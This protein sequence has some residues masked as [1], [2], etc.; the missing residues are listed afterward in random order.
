MTTLET[1]ETQESR[2]SKYI[3]MGAAAFIIVLGG[4]GVYGCRKANQRDAAV[5]QADVSHKAAAA[6]ATAATRLDVQEVTQAA[7]SQAA[8]V[9]VQ[10]DSITTAQARADLA[11]VRKAPQVPPAAPGAPPIQAEALPVNLEDVVA[12]QDALI[13]DQDKQIGD[14]TAQVQ[15]QDIQIHTLTLSR[16]TWKASAGDSAQEALQLRAAL[17]AQKGV[18]A[19]AKLKYGLG[20]FLFGAAAGRTVR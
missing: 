1:L 7:T 14:L 16:D 10:A 4:A 9:K 13:Q 3:L 19:A 17:L 5:A 2:T 20:G 6:E 18:L 12:K 11:R 15:D 8:G